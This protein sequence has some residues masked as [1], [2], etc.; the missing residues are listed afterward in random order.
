MR[1]ADVF[2]F[3]HMEKNAAHQFIIDQNMNSVRHMAL[4]GFSD[5]SR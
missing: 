2:S 1:A 4:L 5:R 3:S